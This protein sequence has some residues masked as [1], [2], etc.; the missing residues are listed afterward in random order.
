MWEQ[1]KTCLC[2]ENIDMELIK[3]SHY[4]LIKVSPFFLSFHCKRKTYNLNNPHFILVWLYWNNFWS[5]IDLGLKSE[6]SCFQL[7]EIYISEPPKEPSIICLLVFIPLCP[8]HNGCL[9]I[10]L[11]EYGRS[12]VMHSKSPTCKPSRCEFSKI[13]TYVHM[14]NQ[15]S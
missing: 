6:S 2:V 11:T 8:F 14:S 1:D 12:E 7:F 13:W 5:H 3:V 15:I 9:L 10:W 4:S